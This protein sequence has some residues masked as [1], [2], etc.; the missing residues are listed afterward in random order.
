MCSVLSVIVE[1][2]AATSRGQQLQHLITTPA[3]QQVPR[4][5]GGTKQRTKARVHVA[6][7]GPIIVTNQHICS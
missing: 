3:I 7:Q 5:S 4:A 1:R 6:A 2:F